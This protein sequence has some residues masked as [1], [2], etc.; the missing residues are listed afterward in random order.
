[1]ST[2]LPSSAAERLE[3]L[4]KIEAT[5]NLK[6]LLKRRSFGGSYIFVY[7]HSHYG[8]VYLSKL[9]TTPEKPDILVEQSDHPG[10]EDYVLQYVLT[11]ERGVIQDIYIEL[12][13]ALS[14]SRNLVSFAS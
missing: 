9:D 10:G 1:M 11:G 4:L 3:K 14:L 5:E 12:V 13:V 2:S 8:D 7:T 6:W